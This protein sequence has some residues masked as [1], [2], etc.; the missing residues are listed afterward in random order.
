MN[1]DIEFFLS[2]QMRI[3]HY[4]PCRVNRPGIGWGSAG[5]RDSLLTH[6]T[7]MWYHARI[8]QRERVSL[9]VT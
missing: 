3:I 1:I 8:V 5:L 2:F 6:E 9:A 7:E 4:L